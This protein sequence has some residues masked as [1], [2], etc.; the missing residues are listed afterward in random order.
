MNKYAVK[1]LIK[2][3]SFILKNRNV[4]S[5]RSIYNYIYIYIFFKILLFN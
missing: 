1:L 4:T 5:C 3:K 2:K